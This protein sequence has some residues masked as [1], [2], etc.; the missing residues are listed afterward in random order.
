MYLLANATY[1]Q[2][3]LKD[4]KRGMLNDM[5]Y[6]LYYCYLNGQRSLKKGRTTSRRGKMSVTPGNVQ[7]RKKTQM[8][9]RRRPWSVAAAMEEK[10]RDVQML[11]LT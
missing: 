1:Q 2:K 6:I 9:Q 11:Q 5:R 3:K 10:K 4:C 7:G 8:K